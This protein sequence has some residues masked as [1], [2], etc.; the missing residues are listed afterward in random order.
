MAYF[1]VKTEKEI[2]VVVETDENVVKFVVYIDGLRY[3]IATLSEDGFVEL[4][5]C[6]IKAAGFSY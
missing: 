2:K 5:G 6:E 3:V 4:N 1:Q